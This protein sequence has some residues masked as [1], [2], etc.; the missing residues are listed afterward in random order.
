MNFHV[1]FVT[2]GNTD[3]DQ[4]ALMRTRYLAAYLALTG[5]MVFSCTGPT[6]PQEAEKQ[7]LRVEFSSP[8]T[9]WKMKTLETKTFYYETVKGK[10]THSSMTIAYQIVDSGTIKDSIKYF[11][12]N[13]F[14]PVLPD[15]KLV[16][17]I[18]EYDTLYP[19]STDTAGSHSFSDILVSSYVWLEG[20]YVTADVKDIFPV[21]INGQ[22]YPACWEYTYQDKTLWVDGFGMVFKKYDYFDTRA[23]VRTSSITYMMEFNGGKINCPFL[24]SLK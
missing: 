6:G 23:L 9:S 3:P 17:R 14:D 7:K 1:I 12:D 20:Q 18:T 8:G 22:P 4:E 15:F 11:V 19:S 10:I 5:I 24:E 21:E 16:T 13:S 2:E